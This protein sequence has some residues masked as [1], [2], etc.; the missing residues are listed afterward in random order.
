MTPRAFAIAV[1]AI[2]LV[3]GIFL[4]MNRFTAATAGLEAQCLSYFEGKGGVLNYE[5]GANY[6][7]PG[8]DRLGEKCES[9]RE[10]FGIVTWILIAG[11]ALVIAGGALIRPSRRPADEVASE[12]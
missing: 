7:S 3:V 10:M 1:G 6:Y 11:G 12:Q 9:K 2:A 5:N 4:G 8:A